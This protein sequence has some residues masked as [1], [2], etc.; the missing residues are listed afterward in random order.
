MFGMWTDAAGMRPKMTEDA[1][2]F[3]PTLAVRQD[4]L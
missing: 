2:L 1:A 4:T 3:R